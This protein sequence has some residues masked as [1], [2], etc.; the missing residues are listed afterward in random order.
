M[1]ALEL[2]GLPYE[3]SGG[4]SKMTVTGGDVYVERHRGL[5]EY[6]DGFIAISTG[7]G[8]ARFFGSNLSLAA[9]SGDEMRIN[10]ELE[11]IEFAR[12]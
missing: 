9:M 8:T 7:D 10:G 1:R 2:F 5:V 12:R 3:L 4:V 6:D 11:R